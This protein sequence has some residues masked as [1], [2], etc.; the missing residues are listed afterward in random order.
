MTFLAMTSVH[1]G[2]GVYS[3]DLSSVVFEA[4][5]IYRIDKLP[6]GSL[7]LSYTDNFG[8]ENSTII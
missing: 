6:S 2:K 1:V 4:D 3:K 8:I 5:K 7:K